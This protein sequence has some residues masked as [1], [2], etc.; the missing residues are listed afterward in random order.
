MIPLT[1]AGWTCKFLNKNSPY[2][3]WLTNGSYMTACSRTLSM[4]HCDFK[5]AMLVREDPI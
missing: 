5:V 4:F 3:A 1:V 2:C